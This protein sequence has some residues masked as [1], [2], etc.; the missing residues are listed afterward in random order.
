ML[1]SVH[2]SGW[3]HLEFAPDQE[4][5][6]IQLGNTRSKSSNSENPPD[7]NNKDASK[8]MY[9]VA[10]ILQN[11]PPGR[12]YYL[13][14]RYSIHRSELHVAKGEEKKEENAY[15]TLHGEAQ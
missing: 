8:R 12:A 10:Y 11:D 13:P 3:K 7:T 14:E 9:M 4:K 2:S 5:C 6:I 1:D 15:N